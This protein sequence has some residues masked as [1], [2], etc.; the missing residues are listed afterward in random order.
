MKKLL[1]TSL[2]AL[3]LTAQA[4]NQ[5]RFN[6]DMEYYNLDKGKSYTIVVLLTPF[7]AD[8][9]LKDASNL[10][11][12]GDPSKW[13]ALEDKL[14][15]AIKKGEN[16]MP[17]TYMSHCASATKYAGAMWQYATYMTSNNFG[18][19]DNPE[20]ANLKMYKKAKMKFQD[21]FQ[22]CKSAVNNPP[23]QKDY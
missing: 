16:I 6:E 1:I 8:N 15:A 13:L 23:N 11:N 18:E 22:K 4:F 20:A 14:S 5:E 3:S 19:W 2:F 10:Y 7:N 9:T 12:N 21:V 17:D